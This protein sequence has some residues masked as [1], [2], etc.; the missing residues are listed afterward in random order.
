MKK[1]LIGALLLLA[2]VSFAQVSKDIKVVTWDDSTAFSESFELSWFQSPV[3]ILIPAGT[4]T[5]SQKY[6]IQY[7]NP[8]TSVWCELQKAGSA[9]EVNVTTNTNTAVALMPDDFFGSTAV[10]RFRAGTVASPVT[11][12]SLVK[13]YVIYR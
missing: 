4:A 8:I 2:S 11:I 1:L 12:N 9:Y 7:W 6:T 13:L 5:A 3:G 10:I